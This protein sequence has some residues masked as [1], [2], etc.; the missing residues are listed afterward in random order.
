MKAIEK[1]ALSGAQGLVTSDLAWLRDLLTAPVKIFQR[2]PSYNDSAQES[3]AEGSDHMAVRGE[4]GADLLLGRSGNDSLR[5][6]GGDDTLTGGNGHDRLTG[7]VGKDALMGG[8]GND[9]LLGGGGDDRLS[10][11][12]GQDVLSGGYGNDTL[13]SSSGRSQMSGGAGND[14]LHA[15]LRQSGHDMTGGS[16]VDTF[17]LHSGS[18]NSASVITDYSAE[19]IVILEGQRLVLENPATGMT[20]TTETDGTLVTF[21]A[22]DTVLLADFWL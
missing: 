1:T 7:G 15:D 6:I 20:I 11:N 9:T 17:I 12:G 16:G 4:A 22:G 19:D 13:S 2:A 14:R 21:G 5:G 8:A 18:G 3:S 10:G